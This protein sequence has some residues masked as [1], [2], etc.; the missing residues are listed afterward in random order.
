MRHAANAGVE[1]AA[2]EQF[3][4]ALDW[5]RH[6]GLPSSIYESES[7]RPCDGLRAGRAALRT[8]EAQTNTVGLYAFDTVDLGTLAVQRRASLGTTTTR[9]S[10]PQTQL[11]S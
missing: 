3:A 5:H 8:A 10:R 11:A 2:E 6:A 9:R 7:V 4:P 1:F